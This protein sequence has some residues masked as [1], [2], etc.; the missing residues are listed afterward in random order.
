M[1]GYCISVIAFL[2]FNSKVLKGLGAVHK[3]H[4]QKEGASG[5]KMSNFWIMIIKYKIS[6]E[7]VRWSK[8]YNIGCENCPWKEKSQKCKKILTN[9]TI[10][11]KRC[12]SSILLLFCFDPM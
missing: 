1:K 3:I 9:C 5:P 12:Y 7:G 6:T 2:N 10:Q 4:L 8:N 11:L